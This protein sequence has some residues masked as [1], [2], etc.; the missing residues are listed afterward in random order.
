M[1]P[2][3]PFRAF[4]R[5][6]VPGALATLTQA[7]PIAQQFQAQK[8][9]EQLTDIFSKNITE[10][11][12]GG[13]QLNKQGALADL[14][15]TQPGTALKFETA[16]AKAAP[17]P[18]DIRKRA[19][20]DI[21]M[22]SNIL[23]GTTDPIQASRALVNAGLD[24]S[25]MPPPGSA[26]WEK[27][28][29]NKVSM[30]VGAK[31]LFSIEQRK[32]DRKRRDKQL[33]IMVDKLGIE[34]SK[35]G[36][37][38]RKLT[39]SEK[40]LDIKEQKAGREARK[41]IEAHK[42]MRLK[43]S[44]QIL[45]IEAFADLAES[46]AL[47]QN[48]KFVTGLGMLGKFVPG[49]PAADLDVDL[50]RLIG[51]GAIATMGKLKAESPTGSTGFGALSQKELQVIQDA[52]AGLTRKQTPSKMRKELSRISQKMRAYVDNINRFE[53]EG[54]AIMREQGIFLEAPEEGITTPSGY[55]IR[56]KQ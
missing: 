26:D 48:L 43:K 29:E 23:S 16:W 40:E 42:A 47:N 38:K 25:D 55:K 34:R 51:M 28:K 5:Q 1:P 39:I 19:R 6:P 7:G 11:P 15:A 54:E 13:I 18:I 20:E 56:F 30:G 14:Y 32:L 4:S 3:D 24:V 10:T 37:A 9:Q 36:I 31:D 21:G 33:D 49:T 41:S 27:W 52:F 35:L 8:Q 12:E 50:N 2:F 53:A 44:E 22:F 45:E 17:K 46:I